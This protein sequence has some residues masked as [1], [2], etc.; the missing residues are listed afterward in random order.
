MS[1]G[2]KFVRRAQAH[3]TIPQ[4]APTPE[5]GRGTYRR[6]SVPPKIMHSGHPLVSDAGPMRAHFDRKRK[7]RLDEWMQQRVDQLGCFGIAAR[8]AKRI[9]I[10]ASA[11]PAASVNMCAASAKSARL[12]V[13]RPP[14]T[15]TAINVENQRP[16]EPAL[17]PPRGGSG[18]SRRRV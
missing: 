17:V 9:A 12:P 15:P 11:K 10:S 3:L 6:C 4:I 18:T 16:Y 2:F 1:T 8:S 7:A 5:S 14:I 13:H